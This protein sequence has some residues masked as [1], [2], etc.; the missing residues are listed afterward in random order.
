MIIYSSINVK[1]CVVCFI[2]QGPNETYT[3]LNDK[4]GHYHKYVYIVDGQSTGFNTIDG[5][6]A[7]E[8]T[9]VKNKLYDISYTQGH[10]I[11]TTTSDI[12]VGLVTFNPIPVDNDIS[13]EIL[14]GEQ[15]VDITS[16][17]TR[18]T[19]VCLSGSLSV[20][21]NVISTNQFA[22]LNVGKTASVTMGE[23]DI[24]AIITG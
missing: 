20:N 13:V 24:C 7:E 8:Y 21:G 15:V 23:T 3:Y 1:S 2:Y 12:G 18:K 4:L 14:K 5:V 16:T 17:D 22:T 9:L 19:L 11:T 6:D 10:T